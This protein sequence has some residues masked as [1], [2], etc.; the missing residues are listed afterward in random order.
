MHRKGLLDD[1]LSPFKPVLCTQLPGVSRSGNVGR[2]YDA[3][4]SRGSTPVLKK[5]RTGYHPLELRR[6][7]YEETLRNAVSSASVVANSREGRY[8]PGYTAKRKMCG[9]MKR[10]F[11]LLYYDLI[12]HVQ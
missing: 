7:I 4:A 10:T 6:T 12:L 8:T 11:W 2:T 9:A 5:L 3:S 1:R